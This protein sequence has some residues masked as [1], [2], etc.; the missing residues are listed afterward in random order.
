MSLRALAQTCTRLVLLSL[1]VTGCGRTGGA[2]GTY[3]DEH[4]LPLDTMSLAAPTIGGYGGRFVLAQTTGPKVFNALIA[5]E[6]STTDL[7]NLLF[8]GLADFDNLTQKDTPLL[9]KS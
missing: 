6:T 2:A 9:A 4:A 7:T 5:N 3:R 8:T 1:L